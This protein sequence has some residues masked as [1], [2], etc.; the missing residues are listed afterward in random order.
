MDLKEGTL[1][2]FLF[3]RQPARMREVATRK[4][5]G[6]RHTYK[7]THRSKK[8]SF[9]ERRDRTRNETAFFR[10]VNLIQLCAAFWD[11]IMSTCLEK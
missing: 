7:L 1:Y 3:A 11:K 4:S 6:G 5:W 9:S 10:V 8:M 2:I